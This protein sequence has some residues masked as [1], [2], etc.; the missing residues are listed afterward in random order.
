MLLELIFGSGISDLPEQFHIIGDEDV[1]LQSDI[2][3][4]QGM[5]NAFNDD[6]YNK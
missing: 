3:M 2:T 1:T 4:V 6:K 5:A